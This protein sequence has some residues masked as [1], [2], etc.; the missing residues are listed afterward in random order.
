[1]NVVSLANPDMALPLYVMVI[2]AAVMLTG[3]WGAIVTAVH[4]AGT[5]A[6]AK[7]GTR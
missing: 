5:A 6:T 2:L 3:R 1:M 7:S 4:S